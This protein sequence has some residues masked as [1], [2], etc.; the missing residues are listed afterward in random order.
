TNHMPRLLTIVAAALLLAL[1]APPAFAQDKPVE[2]LV[3]AVV[4]IK[5]WINPDAR[6][7][8][9]LGHQREGSGV[10]LDSNGLVL[11]IGYLMV[12]AQAAEIVT[13]DGRAVPANIVG[14]DHESGFGLLQAASPLKV[15][16]IAMGSSAAVKQGEG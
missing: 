1:Q 14:Y 6:T 4:K 16:P 7:G 12:E 15:Q 10:V 9:N 11:T 8:E 13:N 5:T 3:S 2:D